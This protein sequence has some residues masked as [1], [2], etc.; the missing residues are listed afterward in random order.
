MKHIFLSTIQNW[1][2][3]YRAST[4]GLEYPKERDH[5]GDL[6]VDARITLERILKH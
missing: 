1:P 6:D 3:N 4:Q 2:Q 5:L